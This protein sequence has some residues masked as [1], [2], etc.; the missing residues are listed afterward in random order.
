KERNK[1]ERLVNRFKSFRRIAT[2]YDKRA[3]CFQAWLTIA[4]ILLWL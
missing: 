4:S 3:R 1:V 2:R